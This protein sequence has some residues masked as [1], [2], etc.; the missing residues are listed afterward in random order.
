MDIFQE[1]GETFRTSLSAKPVISAT[2]EPKY[3]GDEIILI[4]SWALGEYCSLIYLTI[5]N[6]HKKTKII[7]V[8]A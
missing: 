6:T 7:L 4:C 2:L 5:Q 8:S 1:R 3:W